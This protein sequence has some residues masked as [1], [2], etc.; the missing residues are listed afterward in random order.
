MHTVLS[1]LGPPGDVTALLAIEGPEVAAIFQPLV[2]HLSHA[3]SLLDVFRS[4]SVFFAAHSR[5]H[6]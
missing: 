6:S 1:L 2:D 5:G 3:S 4:V